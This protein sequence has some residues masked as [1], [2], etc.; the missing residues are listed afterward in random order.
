MIW[1]ED[2]SLKRLQASEKTGMIRHIN[3]L[4]HH[5]HVKLKNIYFNGNLPKHSTLHEFW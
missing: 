1:F 2:L 4:K 5:P 3:I